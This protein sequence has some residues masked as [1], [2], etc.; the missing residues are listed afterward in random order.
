MVQHIHATTFFQLTD[1]ILNRKST[2]RKKASIIENKA[3]KIDNCIWNCVEP[4]QEGYI[5]QK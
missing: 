1:R 4:M 2:G 3:S 5:I